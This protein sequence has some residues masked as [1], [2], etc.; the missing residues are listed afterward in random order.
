MKPRAFTLIELL[1]VIAIIVALLAIL[2]PSLNQAMAVT[3]QAVCTSNQKQIGVGMQT[4]LADHYGRFPAYRFAESM[5]AGTTGSDVQ[6][7]WF[8]K[9]RERM[10]GGGDDV[11]DDFALFGCPTDEN[12]QYDA[13]RISYGY[14]Y[15]NFG[16]AP[17]NVWVSITQVSQPA[18]TIIVGDSVG[19]YSGTTKLWGSV[20]SPLDINV[21]G[22]P[23]GA[24]NHY[25]LDARHPNGSAAIL[26]AD[27][28][29]AAHE[30]DPLN[31]QIRGT[32]TPYWWDANEGNRYLYHN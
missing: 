1:V 29:A 26:F 27:G 23:A 22:G 21:I 24:H 15:T 20:I 9:F 2:L 8:D 31:N 11:P 19:I 25:R 14:N 17:Y 5:F 28:H 18:E 10:V 4:Y 30:A 32:A 12:Y 6:Y 13:N 3:E 16:D 7:H